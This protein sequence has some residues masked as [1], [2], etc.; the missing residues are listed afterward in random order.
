MEQNPYK[1]WV[2]IALVLTCLAVG[3]LLGQVL[4]LAW[5]GFDLPLKEEWPIQ[6]PMGIG[7]LVCLL[8]LVFIKSHA[9]AMG[10]LYEVANETAKVF[11]P[12]PKETGLSTVVVIVMVGIAS[13]IFALYDGVFG[14]LTNKLFG[15]D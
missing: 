7:L 15:M 12:Q 8:A 13:L 14:T 2:D 11:W 3:V 10:F 6:M 5:E 1:K 4:T 9:K